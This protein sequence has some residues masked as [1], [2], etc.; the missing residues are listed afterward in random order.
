[1]CDTRHSRHFCRPFRRFQ[2]LEEQTPVFSWT[3]CTFVIF[4]IFSP[5]SIQKRPEP[6]ICPKFVPT[7][8]FRGFN[9]GDPNLSK[10]CRKFENLSGN[11]RFF[12]FFNFRHDKFGS[13]LIGTPKNNRRDKFWT[14]LGFG[15]FLNAVRGKR[16]RKYILVKTCCFWKG[17]KPRLP[18]TPCASSRSSQEKNSTALDE[19]SEGVETSS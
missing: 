18:K 15:A 13:P 11:C 19:S 1:M 2:E 4:A 9:Q 14:N 16:V 7:I 6:Q 17:Q 5:Y 8:A 3:D 10:I 12:F